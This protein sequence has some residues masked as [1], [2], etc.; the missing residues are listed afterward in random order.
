MGKLCGAAVRDR[1]PFALIGRWDKFPGVDSVGWMN[2]YSQPTSFLGRKKKIHKSSD[3]L[4]SQYR[5]VASINNG[6]ISWH[7]ESFGKATLLQKVFM[8]IVHNQSFP[9]PVTSECFTCI[10]SPWVPMSYKRTFPVA[11]S[12]KENASESP[13][14]P[15]ARNLELSD[16]Y[17]VMPMVLKE[18]WGNAGHLGFCQSQGWLCGSVFWVLSTMYKALQSNMDASFKS[19]PKFPTHTWFFK[20]YPSNRTVKVRIKAY[21]LSITT[22]NYGLTVSKRELGAKFLT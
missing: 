21:F 1:G 19:S 10:S 11:F 13:I 14:L 8:G 7:A 6:Q 2:G 20:V 5:R 3:E 16:H 15:K 4:R 18:K 9:M 22:R 12:L 17:T